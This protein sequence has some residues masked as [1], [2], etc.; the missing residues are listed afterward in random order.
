MGKIVVLWSER[1]KK[2]EKRAQNWAIYDSVMSLFSTL[3]QC[4]NFSFPSLD[5]LKSSSMTHLEYLILWSQFTLTHYSQ[6]RTFRKRLTQGN[7]LHIDA[8]FHI[9]PS[10]LLLKLLPR[11]QFPQIVGFKYSNQ[12]N[13]H[14]DM[15]HKVF[16]SRNTC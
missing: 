5:H 4:F 10:S 7:L 12:S 13:L 2:E 1:T 16:F 15:L 3:I 8:N 6:V 14:R 11:F 9:V